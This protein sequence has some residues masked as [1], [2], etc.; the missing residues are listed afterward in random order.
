MNLNRFFFNSRRKKAKKGQE[1]KVTL[2]TLCIK[3]LKRF[4]QTF[5]RRNHIP[6]TLQSR[7]YCEIFCFKLKSPLRRDRLNSKVKL[8]YLKPQNAVFSTLS[9]LTWPKVPEPIIIFEELINREGSPARPYWC[10][11]VKWHWFWRG[12]QKPV[13]ISTW[14]VFP[15][16]PSQKLNND[17]VR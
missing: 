10:F 11:V 9:F 17:V 12:R 1:F 15:L 16:R 8:F 13:A 4:L 7:L 14:R 3:A 6:A 5:F 2:L